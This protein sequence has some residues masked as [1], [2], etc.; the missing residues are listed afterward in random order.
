MSNISSPFVLAFTNYA[1]DPYRLLVESIVDYAIYMVDPARRIASWNSAAERIYGYRAEEIIGQ[2]FSTVF[3]PQAE[4]DSSPDELCQLALASGH[5][6]FEC[7]RARKDKSLFRAVVSVSSLKNHSGNHAGFSVVTRNVIEQQRAEVASPESAE[8]H[9]RLLDVLPDALFLNND[10][11]IAYGNSAFVEL[12]GA[13]SSE[14]LRDRDAMSIFHP[15]YH[16]VIRQQ[17]ESLQFHNR[18]VPLAEAEVV[19]LNGEVVPVKVAATTITHQGR[20]SILA[21]LHD[22]GREKEVE[23]RFRSMIDGIK[24]YAIYMMDRDGII[25]TWNDGAAHIYGYTTGEILGLHRN[26][27]FTAEDVAAGIVQDEMDFA[28]VNG[29]FSEDRW[30]VRKDGSRFWANGVMTVL[31]DSSGRVHG[32]MKIIRDST[33]QKQANAALNESEE[34]YRR[35]FDAIADPLFVYDRETL[36]YLA[37]NEAAV[38]KYG[39]SSDEFLGMTIKDIRPVEDIA[40]LLEMLAAAGDL[41]PGR[42][43]IIKLELGLSQRQPASIAEA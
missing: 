28:A 19:R 22:I 32:F 14:E 15:K 30:R 34:R 4:T 31:R 43:P 21:V 11:R 27:L 26:L 36:E 33:E 10:G 29:S 25:T 13:S 35:L 18:T 16:G 6:E 24:E 37:V 2:P 9:R 3:A 39:Y 20:Q 1:D 38:Q 41:P 8:L 23:R 40:A 5:C 42:E 12:F 17:L 7:L